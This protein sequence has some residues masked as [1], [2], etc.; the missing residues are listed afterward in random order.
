MGRMK[1]N[2][3]WV[4]MLAAL[5]LVLAPV[6]AWADE[7]VSLSGR[8]EPADIELIK[9]P[10]SGS[11]V[12][13][14]AEAGDLLETGASLMMIDT[15]RIYAPCDGVAAAIRAEEGDRLSVVQAFYGTAMY[16]EPA[17]EY[18]ISASTT[19]AY[20]SNANRMI[21]VGEKVYLTSVN[22]YSRTG[23]GIVTSVTGENY[24]VEVL[25]GNLRLNETCRISRDEDNDEEKGRI[26]QGKTQRNN[27]IAI[28]AEGSVL[29]IH[30]QEGDE[31]RKGDLLM[32]IVPDL[33]EGKAES[34]IAAEKKCVV[35]AVNAAEGGVVQ[36]GQP[37]AQVFEAGTLR[38]VVQAEEEDLKELAEG[39]KVTVTLDI[40]PEK[41]VYEGVIEKIS[42]V[43]VE[44]AMGLTYE[45]TVSFE[46]DG[47][48]R[49]G[50]SVTVET[51]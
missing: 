17:S 1:K 40:D 10:V 38:A 7:G 8:L 36:K 15:V 32:E 33:L 20:D 18:V 14:P 27:P 28:Q 29:K 44:T 46:N 13:C 41:Y 34:V 31:V 16:V 23:E 21:H 19:N 30:V 37:V 22:N 39:D 35:L 25:E 50:M 12:E 3:K 24:T 9:A 43:P 6:S 26:G 11:V 49:M 47:F 45:V 51:R 2:S 5:L 42:H 4:C 48:V